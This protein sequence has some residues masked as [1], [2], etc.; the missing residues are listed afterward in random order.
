MQR[1]TRSSSWRRMLAIGGLVACGA[2]LAQADGCGPYKV[3]FH[4]LGQLYRVDETGHPEGVD[5]DVVAALAK[6][7]GCSFVAD[8]DSRVRIWEAIRSGQLDLT[9]SVIPTPEREA[10]GDIVVYKT[11]R[12]RLLVRSGAAAGLT[13]L[14]A[15]VQ[16]DKV[17]VVVVRSFIYAEPF[18]AWL[19]QLREQGKVYEAGDFNAALRV[20]AAGRADAMIAHSS[21]E[22]EVAQAMAG[23]GGV[24][25]IEV[26]GAH[27]FPSGLLISKRT[28]DDADRQL[29][30][31]TLTDMVRDGTVAAI[32]KR[33]ADGA[34]AP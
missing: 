32:L 29:L 20:F 31:K 24:R 21:T 7:S 23:H 16:R 19:K 13:S 4:V 28:V 18:D 5:K 8:V 11:S 22:A 12:N 27:E 9:T 17:R 3:G 25:A 26:A 2:P 10:L 15:F 33:H 14:A 6:R 34:A 30:R 1:R